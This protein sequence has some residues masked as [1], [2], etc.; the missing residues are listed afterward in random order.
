MSMKAMAIAE[1]R[2]LQPVDLDE[3]PLAPGQV[4]L[5]VAF[6]GICGSDLHMIEIPMVPA[7]TV[8]GHEL[9]GTITE[10]GDGV[11]GWQAGDRVT[12]FPFAPCG[13]CSVCAAGRE[14]LCPE[15]MMGGIGLGARPGGYAETVVV[16][17]AM[18][19][20]LPEAVSDQHGALVEPLAVAVHG[21]ALGDLA[22]GDRACVIGAGPIGVMTAFALHARGHEDVTIVELN[23]AR[24]ELAAGLGFDVVAPDVA[25]EHLA[26]RPPQVIF[27]CTGHPAGAVSAVALAP[28]G[29][30]IVMLGVTMEATSLYTA[31]LVT[32]E[33]DLRGSMAYRRAEFAEAID[34]LA[35]GRVPADRLITTVAPMVEADRWFRELTSGST[36]QV[37]VLLA[38]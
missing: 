25:G 26:H 32:K 16:D 38:P 1:D 37:K 21:V 3:T 14:H 30:R 24:R 15:S 9:S 6:C 11:D 29:G 27:D 34:H 7:G 20:R 2:T 12:V 17:A 19:E 18:L 13:R 10:V 33:L 36:D 35:A 28:P 5:D 22:T 8:M 4:R 23:P 31:M